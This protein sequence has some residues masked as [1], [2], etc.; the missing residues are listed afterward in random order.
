MH[1]HWVT[2]EERG[3]CALCDAGRLHAVVTVTQSAQPEG[4]THYVR[5]S[6]CHSLIADRLLPPP[7]VG[8]TFLSYYLEQGAGIEVMVEP[9]LRVTDARRF[10]EVGCGFG[11]AVDFARHALQ[12]DVC[13][14]DAGS[15]AVEGA[16][17]LGIPILQ[18]H[19]NR[20]L[21]LGGLFDLALASEV[22]EHVETPLQF[23][24]DLRSAL[25]DDGLLR[26]MTPDAEI[27][28]PHTDL[29]MLGR[30][31][32]PGYHAVLLSH[33][34]LGRVL[35]R[36]GLPHIA[37][38]SV[39]GTLRCWASPT[40]AGLK[41][42]STPSGQSLDV[43]A[44]YLKQRAGHFPSD[45]ALRL[46]FDYRSFKMDVNAGHY[47]EA[48]DSL[49]ALQRSFMARHGVD[50]AQP[51]SAVS[52]MDT[53][54]RCGRGEADIK[55]WP[56]C[57]ANALFFIGILELNAR[58][59]VEEAERAFAAAIS[60]GV[61]LLAAERGVG[62]H[63]G[64][65]PDLVAQSRLHRLITICR[66]RPDRA[67][68]EFD[69]LLASPVAEEIPAPALCRLRAQL[70]MESVHAGGFDAAAAF[71]PNV[72]ENLGAISDP[73]ASANLAYALGLL[74]Y[75]RGRI[76]E[77][78]AW[79]GLA[80][81]TPAE[82]A[83][84]AFRA[85]ARAK[86][87]E[88]MRAATSR[89][90][91]TPL[92]TRRPPVAHG[93]DVFWCDSWGLYLS[94]WIHAYDLRITSFTVRCAGHEAVVTTF[95]DRSDVGALFPHHFHAR[96][97]GFSVYLHAR[98]G[99]PVEVELTFDN[100]TTLDMPLPL[101]HGPLPAWPAERSE[102][103][104]LV[105]RNYL[106]D[107]PARSRVLLIGA[108]YAPAHDGD[109]HPILDGITHLKAWG[110]DIHPGPGV[111]VVADVHRLAST[112][113]RGSIDAVASSS[114]FEHL[115]APWVAAAE[116]NRVLRI[117]GTVHHD[118]PYAWPAHS[119]PNDF[120]RFSADGLRELFGPATGFEILSAANI[121]RMTMV[122]EPNWRSGYLNMPTVPA[123]GGAAIVARK[124][125]EI[126]DAAVVWP[127]DTGESARRARTYPVA[128]VATRED[129]QMSEAK[130]TVP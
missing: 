64:E 55:N 89:V 37:W 111:D 33:D 129:A 96:S 106:S 123:F 105:L 126:D 54:F 127:V 28:E 62:I 119:E 15:V 3:K 46:G 1:I 17:S 101:P 112:F 50:L 114:V 72:V 100:G 87:A 31:L 107:L 116:I 118:T 109:P 35:A 49:K 82:S 90:S 83:P 68:H 97:S 115:A 23:L 4:V 16:K 61:Q 27:V 5:C 104:H 18:K 39:P 120:W 91:P 19:F 51:E 52:A 71:E 26:V 69:E 74:A 9:L 29:D 108:R 42:L 88:V 2:S 75:H 41:R 92:P 121:G 130:V 70:L 94:G 103:P 86:L 78:I 11:F 14:I 110:V 76:S 45:S 48:E 25:T 117:G 24:G 36:A 59:R 8:A 66:R 73:L 32:S 65:T 95:R 53:L 34:S 113:Q 7:D 21:Q 125:R 22:L 43:V 63:D 124:V 81:D 128:G 58:R 38:D 98:P 93:L 30:T 85:L 44:R 79:L 56:F 67:R 60:I 47:A 99:E 77:S 10:L 13:G 20:D 40:A 6:A 57:L 84:E 80:G 122:P 102:H 12:L